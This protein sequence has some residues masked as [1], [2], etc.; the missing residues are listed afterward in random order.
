MS[1]FKGRIQRGQFGGKEVSRT[2]SKDSGLRLVGEGE[3]GVV[4]VCLYVDSQ[5]RDCYRITVENKHTGEQL[6]KP[7]EG[8]LQ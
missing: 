6:R 2:G 4:T 1:R 7:I 8:H 3:R 5:D